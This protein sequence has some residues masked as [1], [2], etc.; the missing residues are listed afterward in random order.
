MQMTGGRSEASSFYEWVGWA[1]HT[2]S[3][4]YKAY[5]TEF[6]RGCQELDLVVALLLKQSTLKMAKL[7]SSPFV[8][9][10]ALRSSLY[11]AFQHA[12]KIVPS[13]EIAVQDPSLLLHSSTPPDS[14]G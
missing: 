8:R 1:G 6:K 11:A 4:S 5:H 9:K 3:P 2:L 14:R 7:W 10:R 12:V 13:A